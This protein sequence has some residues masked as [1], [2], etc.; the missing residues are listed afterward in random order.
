MKPIALVAPLINLLLL[1]LILLT[2]HLTELLLPCP[3]PGNKSESRGNALAQK[4]V[5]L[6]PF[7]EVL[8][9]KGGKI[10]RTGCLHVLALQIDPI[11]LSSP[12]LQDLFH[13]GISVNYYFYDEPI[14]LVAPLTPAHISS[15]MGLIE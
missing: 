13:C 10:Q 15:I 7:T 14:A 3:M 2:Y 6:I 5:Q 4:K 8:Y 9:D 12:R 1:W 11:K